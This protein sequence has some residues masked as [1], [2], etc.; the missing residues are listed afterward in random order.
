MGGIHD[1]SLDDVDRR[2]GGGGDQTSDE[3]GE[4]VNEGTIRK[5]I[6][7]FENDFSV[8]I[9]GELSTSEYSGAEGG[10]AYALVE[11]LDAFSAQYLGESIEGVLVNG[12]LIGAT[13]L[14]PNLDEVSGVRKR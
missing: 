6:Q 10:R 9:A 13:G 3:R 4:E 8:I 7:S 11:A 14:K 2:G 1:A 12:W 5:D